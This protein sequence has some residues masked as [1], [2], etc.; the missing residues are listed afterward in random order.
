MSTPI[1]AILYSTI[2]CIF[3]YSEW[4]YDRKM[5]VI[6][7]WVTITIILG[8]CEDYDQIKPGVI[9]GEQAVYESEAEYILKNVE[10]DESVYLINR[11]DNGFFETVMKY[12]CNP[13]HFLWGSPGMPVNENDVY[14]T[15]YTIEEL[16]AL[17]SDYDYIYFVNLDDDFVWQYSSLF[18]D[19]DKIVNGKLYKISCDDTKIELIDCMDL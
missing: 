14:S 13:I 4:I 11:G 18:K 2:F 15:E 3:E 9:L 12:S 16:Y 1:I 5:F 19:E 8:T 17:I 7:I 10:E 6:I